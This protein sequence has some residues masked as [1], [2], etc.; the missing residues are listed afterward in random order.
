MFK[1]NI[2]MCLGSEA[3]TSAFVQLKVNGTI[4]AD[5][6]PVNTPYNISIP[7]NATDIPFEGGGLNYDSENQPIGNTFEVVNLSSSNGP[8]RTFHLVIGEFNNAANVFYDIM[9][10]EPGPAWNTAINNG[11]TVTSNGAAGWGS[12]TIEPNTSASWL[13]DGLFLT[14]AP[15]PGDI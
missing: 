11:I 2:N 3:T 15:G 9:T 8:I 7:I 1:G 14:H 12:L 4:V 5:N 10:E 6:V 13:L